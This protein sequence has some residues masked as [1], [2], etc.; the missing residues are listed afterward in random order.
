MSTMLIQGGTIVSAT[1]RSDADVLIDGETIVGILAPGQAT[2]MGVVADVLIDAT[3]KYVI[4]GGIDAHT[5]MGH[6]DPDG[7]RADPEEIVAGLDAARQQRAL[8]FAMQEP[9]GYEG[10]NDAVLAAAVVQSAAEFCAAQFAACVLELEIAAADDG[11]GG[12]GES[13]GGRLT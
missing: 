6:A 7:T 13:P 3:G 11:L 10:P 8:I 2:A 1:G 12:E 4:P 5:H 9:E